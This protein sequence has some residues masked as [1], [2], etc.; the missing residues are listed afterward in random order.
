MKAFSFI[1]KVSLI[2]CALSSVFIQ[3][4]YAQIDS[5]LIIKDSSGIDTVAIN[6][7]VK[8]EKKGNQT[9]LLSKS[10]LEEEV[11]YSAEDSI[12]Y[13]IINKK[14]YL[15][16]AAIIDYQDLHL[17][18][19]KVVIDWEKNQM[20][21][22]PKTDSSGK[23][24]KEQV[25]LSDKGRS[26]E[27]DSLIYNFKSQ[28]GKIYNFR[29]KEGNAYVIIEDAKKNERNVMY[30]TNSKFTTCDA[31]HPHFWLELDRAKI[32]PKDKV[33]TSYAYPV[34]EGVPLY[35]AFLPF[36]F[37]PTNTQAASS[38]ILFPKYGFSPGRGYFLQ[39]G[40]YYF[41]MSEKMDLSVTGDIFSYGSWGLG[42]TSNYKVRY[43]YSGNA[44][45]NFNRNFYDNGLGEFEPK[46]EFIINW[47]HRQDPKSI[48]GMTFSS[49]VNIGT[50]GF[51]RNNSLNNDDILNSRL[52]SSINFSKNFKNTPFRLTVALNHNQNLQSRTISFTLPNTNLAMDRIEP[53]KNLRDKRL[54]FLSNLGFTHN[55]SFENRLNTYDSLLFDPEVNPEWDRGVS[56]R[57]P[58]NT[59][60]RLFKW[61]TVTPSF[62]YRGYYNFYR[63]LKELDTAGNV[64]S[65]RESDAAYVFDYNMSTA[66]STTVYGTYN[67]KRSK[68]LVAMRHVMVPNIS[69]NYTPDF[70]D[71]KWGYYDSLT[72]TNLNSKGENIVQYYNKYAINPLGRPQDGKVGSIGFGVNNNVEL[73]LR[74]KKDTVDL[75]ATKKVKII[76]SM[77]FSG[78]YNFFADSM[79]LS[80]ISGRARTTL[81]K[82]VSIQSNV[83]LNPYAI[84][85]E[86][87]SYDKYLWETDQKLA[88][89]QSFN[90]NV[91]TSLK[92]TL[93]EKWLKDQ[94][95]QR[96]IEKQ[97]GII[98]PYTKYYTKYKFPFDIRMTYDYG[99]R[100][101][102]L[103]Y[104]TTQTLNLTGSF[105]PTDK[106][107]V[108]YT[109]N[110][111]LAGQEVSYTRFSFLRD[112][113]CWEFTFD[114]TP[115]GARKGFFFTLRARA[116]ELQ[117]LKIE[118]NKQFWD[119]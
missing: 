44:S 56:H 43:K 58:V 9:V 7:S 26:G 73:K 24:V 75:E 91:G 8:V 29:T 88:M 115:T 113:H 92:K 78:N 53:F 87:R 17:E 86:G 32:I 70:T 67:F 107:S 54:M 33:V 118:K 46:N 72:T 15:Y 38:G 105:E 94:K 85:E 82:K 12:V 114:W 40:G 74:D 63:E 42:A 3:N 22:Y 111:D 5:S 21:A 64:V 51:N 52:R 62:N 25:K 110:Y 41:A 104:T 34:V 90:I 106:W 47:S 71:N 116:A 68:N 76:E 83:T 23:K 61:I 77:T 117:S 95:E 55:M 19:H 79:N 93:I 59:S 109:F 30:A 60:F 2:L 112:L 100:R 18:G 6:D 102:G 4:I 27:A 1:F 35:L 84:N 37:I 101:S 69:F 57:I 49:S 16:G 28:K 81:F 20:S 50:A 45:V 31:K 65:E 48:P 66:L 98:T 13:D 103:E 119:N 80:N 97:K 36:A 14:A 89:V 96:G 108:R 11:Q 39:D 10:A 99:V